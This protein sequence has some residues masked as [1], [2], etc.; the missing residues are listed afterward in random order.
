LFQLKQARISASALGLAVVLIA[1]GTTYGAVI[2]LRSLGFEN[3]FTTIKMSDALKISVSLYL[4]GAAISIASSTLALYMISKGRLRHAGWAGILAAF[5]T[6]ATALG[7]TAFAIEIDALSLTLLAA[8]AMA[9]VLGGVISLRT[10]SVPSKEQFLTTMQ[11]ANS[12][13]LSALTAVVTGIAFV[14]SPTGGYTHLGD[15]I[16]FIAALLFGSKVG[17]I[18]GA[19]GSVAADLWVGY[20]RWFVSIPAHGLEGLIVGLGRRRSLALQVV[21]CVLG[22]LVMASTYFYVNIFIKGWGPAIMSY[23]RDLFGQA[24]VSI[25]LGI[26]LVRTIRRLV[27]RLKA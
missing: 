21:C 12:A 5:F 15:T 18:T 16:I 10:P 3:V 2:I 26:I 8:G 9:S 4:T 14:P 25:I 23:A 20:P 1:A 11:I 22:G 17:G 24:A 13:V 27:P 7:P 6:V 19:I